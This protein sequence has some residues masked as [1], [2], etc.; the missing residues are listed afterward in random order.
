MQVSSFAGSG[1]A[2]WGDDQG[3]QAHFCNP[4]GIVVDGNSN[5]IVVDHSNHRIRKITL[6]G[7]VSTLAGSGLFSW[8]DGKGAEAH[9]RN[10]SGVAVDGSGNIIV[11]DHSNHRIRKICPEGNVSTLAGSGTAG[12]VDG[13]DT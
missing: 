1:N 3:T 12:Y 8:G 5:F 6:N 7:R 10:P 9:F 4:W 13:Q 2:T 11:A